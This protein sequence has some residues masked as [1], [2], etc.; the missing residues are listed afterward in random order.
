MADDLPF[1]SPFW[2]RT[3]SVTSIEDLK[4]LNDERK[5]LLP[6]NLP[7]SPPLDPV[8]TNGDVKMSDVDDLQTSHL[9][10]EVQDS[11]DDNAI[12]GRKLR[13]AQDRILERKRR[14]EKE[15]ERKERAEA[16]AKVPKQ[17]KQ[18][19]KVI[20]DI[21][22][23]EKE[24]AELE[25]KIA[26]IDNDLREAD[27]PRTRVLGKDRFWNRYYWFERNGMP[28]AGL[29]TSSTADAEYANGCIWVQ[30]PDELERE[31]YI[32]MEPKYQNEYKSKFDMTV[33][34]R[35][36]M[37]EGPTS[38][39]NAYQWGFYSEP[40]DVD[41]LLDW[42][43]PRGFNELKLRKEIVMYR[44]RIA[45]HMEA[46]KTYVGPVGG[47]ETNGVNEEEEAEKKRQ[48][49][50]AAA[51]AAV[52]GGKRMSTRGRATA[53]HTPEASAPKTK[54]RCLNWHNTTAIEDLN[55]L[56]SEQ[57]APVRSR[58]QTKRK[59]EAIASAIVAE[60]SEPATTRGKKSRQ[61][62]G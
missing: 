48:E 2:A 11:E 44:D 55:H 39:Y 34:E 41:K 29:P 59:S 60:G 43:D 53:A 3:N 45:T 49:E 1:F 31:G 4:S 51:A 30:G 61:S 8:T 12:G 23:K 5:I 14:A 50:I 33:P 17:S 38:V 22:K 40:E 32:D 46:R 28:Y 57:P 24:I 54:Y 35:K 9:E 7:I 16:A 56:H 19:I 13:R 6:D 62:R 58:K 36:K 27:C 26:E 21:Q 18:F 47:V 37:E 52:K 25:A 15:Q 20:K 42:L 10:E